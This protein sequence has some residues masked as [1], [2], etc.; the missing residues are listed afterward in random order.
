MTEGTE[1][2]QT[3][4]EIGELEEKYDVLAGS[5]SPEAER[6][7]FEKY[8]L[9]W[10]APLTAKADRLRQL[11]DEVTQAQKALSDDVSLQKSLQLQKKMQAMRWLILAL[12]SDLLNLYASVVGQQA[13]IEE[14]RAVRIQPKREKAYS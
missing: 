8:P 4:E 11:V 10:S 3:W 1:I 9:P 12:D 13:T 7:L 14:K 6:A 5:T 2:A